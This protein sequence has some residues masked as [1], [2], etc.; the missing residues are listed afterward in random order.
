MVQVAP[1]CPMSYPTFPLKTH[2]IPVTVAVS[3]LSN[4]ECRCQTAP[5]TA[6]FI[7]LFFLKTCS[8]SSRGWAWWQAPVISATQEAEAEEL[9]E[10]RTQRLQRAGIMPLHSS[11][12]DRASL[13]FKKKIF[14]LVE[15]RSLYVVQAGLEL[16]D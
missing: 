11:L 6:F 2:H 13:C 8:R 9:L 4:S 1:P 14:F 15:M 16:L 12:D 10:S 5:N 7:Q 3:S